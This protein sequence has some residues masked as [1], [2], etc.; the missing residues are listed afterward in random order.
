MTQNHS[1]KQERQTM[2]KKNRNC[3]RKKRTNPTISY[4]NLNSNKQAEKITF[5]LK[6]TEYLEVFVLIDAAPKSKDA[7]K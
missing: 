3:C 5:P 6:P 4:M 2:K 7:H 1:L